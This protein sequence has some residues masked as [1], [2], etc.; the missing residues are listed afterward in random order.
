[1]ST[2]YTLRV[3]IAVP[4][5]FIADANQLALCLGESRSDDQTF[6][7][8][9]HQ[10]TAGNHY[11]VASTVVK[12]AFIE[13]AGASLVPTPTLNVDIEAAER[14]RSLLAI[15]VG[16]VSPG[17]ITVAMGNRLDAVRDHLD[18]LGLAPIDL[19]R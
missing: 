9:M 8:L 19:L 6:G 1:M 5:A 13:L 4:E 7:P 16:N 11:S 2:A 18:Q 17:K 15:N 12:P 3:T 10:D 14:A